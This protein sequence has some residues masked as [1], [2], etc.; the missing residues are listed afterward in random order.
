[1]RERHCTLT[2][3]EWFLQSF[4]ACLPVDSF[5]Q[6]L[7]SLL[8]Q[9]VWYRMLDITST[10]LG[11]SDPSGWLTHSYQVR[12]VFNAA[13]SIINPHFLFHPTPPLHPHTPLLAF[14]PPP[15]WMLEGCWVG[16]SLWSASQSV[17]SRGC[18]DRRAGS[19]QGLC[20][21]LCE[22]WTTPWRALCL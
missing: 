5:L 18:K 4:S 15:A 20:S 1:M 6:L 11:N 13:S 10:C 12:R 9:P 22:A 8:E 14:L 21:R 3:L 16:I 19:F 2:E 7:S 17:T